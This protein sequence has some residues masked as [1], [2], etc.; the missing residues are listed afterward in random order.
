MTLRQR[1]TIALV[2]V[3]AVAAT[4]LPAL[5][6]GVSEW[7]VE[8]GGTF[9]QDDGMILFV[10]T[11]EDFC[12]QGDSPADVHYVETPA[13]RTHAQHH[14][15][16]EL[17][18]Y[19]W[20]GRPPEFLATWCPVINS[21]GHGPDP[22]MTGTGTTDLFV[23]FDEVTRVRAH[24]RVTMVDGDGQTH[25]VHAQVEVLVD[26]ATGPAVQREWIRVR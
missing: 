1:L 25:M 6:Q 5:A 17:T 19:A 23:T 16:G 8:D 10:S 15:A 14:I 4:P 9:W 2:A 24:T 13:D 22:M 3:L 26:P 11:I 18:M 12:T 20:D 7:V 21:G